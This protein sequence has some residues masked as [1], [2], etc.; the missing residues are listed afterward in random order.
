MWETVGYPQD[1]QFQFTSCHSLY[2]K[3]STDFPDINP[4]Q[5]GPANRRN[6]PFGFRHDYQITNL[7]T[8]FELVNERGDD[9]AETA[10]LV[11]S[12]LAKVTPED[13][14]IRGDVD[15]GVI[16]CTRGGQRPP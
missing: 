3:I 11:P 12:G 14:C 7:L 4:G 16:R 5:S 15:L 6:I 9:G 8:L 1:R 13:L 2:S 10:S